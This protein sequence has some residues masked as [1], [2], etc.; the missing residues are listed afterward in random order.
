MVLDLSLLFC[1]KRLKG[2]LL[3]FT[4]LSTVTFVYHRWITALRR[5]TKKNPLLHFF[6]QAQPNPI[7]TNEVYRQFDWTQQ[8]LYKQEGITCDFSDFPDNQAPKKHVVFVECGFRRV[9]FQEFEQ[10]ASLFLY[11]WNQKPMNLQGQTWNTGFLKKTRGFEFLE[12][13]IHLLSLWLVTNMC[14]CMYHVVKE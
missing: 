14:L 12:C 2:T 6:W 7:K 1:I 3:T 10:P 9:V 4:S 11:Q 5:K 13:S 8:E